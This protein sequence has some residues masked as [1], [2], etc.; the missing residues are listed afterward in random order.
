MPIFEIVEE[1]SGARLSRRALAAL[2]VMHHNIVQHV[3]YTG[4]DGSLREMWS[5]EDDWRQENLTEK[6]GAPQANGRPS[7]LYV[8]A[9]T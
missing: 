3:I 5:E 8:R 4:E 7:A 9:A 1:K 6:T 2:P